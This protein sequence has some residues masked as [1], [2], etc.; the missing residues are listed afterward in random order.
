MLA[1][2][3]PRSELD[4]VYTSRINCSGFFLSFR[5]A[6]CGKTKPPFGVRRRHQQAH[7]PEAQ[8]ILHLPCSGKNYVT[9]TL[10]QSRAATINQLVSQLL[11]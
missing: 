7:Q 2:S 6:V 4:L 10:I 9:T 1:S 8:C 5:N 3:P 11:N